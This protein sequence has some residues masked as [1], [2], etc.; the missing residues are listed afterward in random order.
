MKVLYFGIYNPAYPRNRLF[1]KGLRQNGVEVIECNARGSGI[2]KYF[3]LAWQHLNFR[4]KY[5]V[6]IVGF[7]G[8]TVMPLARWLTKKP[9]IFDTFLSLYDSEVHDRKLVSPDSNQAK[10]LLAQDR[11]ACMLAN[12]VLVDT[13][14]HLEYF[15]E[16]LNLPGEKF[17]KIFVGTD[18]EI[19]KPSAKTSDKFIVHVHGKYIPLQGIEYIVEAAKL[20]KDDPI[21]FRIL[22]RGQEYER[23]RQKVGSDN[24]EKVELVS[25]VPYEDLP[26]FIND[27]DIC[28]GIFGK[29]DKTLRVIPNKVVEYLACGKA[30]ITS[31]SPAARELLEDGQNVRFCNPADSADLAKKIRELYQ[32]PDLRHNLG[33]GARKLYLERL[34]PYMLGKELKDLLEKLD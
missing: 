24:L 30:I 32:N 9:I 29:S 22:G 23:I 12:L 18:D 17:R 8:Q 26:K 16:S 6:M 2:F 34:T 5:D 11:R 28:L 4:K 1:I 27:S 15:T 3:K 25:P 20:L 10:I 31:D 19:F 21:Y 14:A 13:Q 7:P 33:E